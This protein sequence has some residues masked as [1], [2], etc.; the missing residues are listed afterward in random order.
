MTA[1]VSRTEI[2]S[3]EAR[4]ILDNRLEPTLRVTVRT[5]DG[6]TGRADVPR[7]RS[8]GVHEVV[9]LRDGGDRYRGMGVK[10]AARNVEE[11]IEPELLGHSVTDQAGIDRRLRELDGTE[12]GSNLGGNALTGV[13]LA[14]LKAGAAAHDLPL[15]RYLGG[16]AAT[17]IPVPL[18]DLIEGGELGA[19]GLPFQEHQ[20]VPTGADGFEDAIRMCAEVYYELGA[21][22]VESH[23]E[24]ALSVGDEGGYTPPSMTD[25]R[26]AFDSILEAIEECGYGDVFELGIDAAAT[27]FYDP[28]E[29][30]YRLAG[31]AY[32]RG[33][34]LDLYAE[35]VETYPLVSIEDPLEENDFEGFAECT[36]RLDAQIVGDDLFVTNAERLRKGIDVGAGDALLC[37]VN[38]VGTVTDAI[39]A[40]ET[41]RRNG[42]A[43]QVSERS[44][45]TADTWLAEVAV[46]L[47]AGQIK[48]GTTRSERTEQYNRLLEIEAECDG[49]YAAWPR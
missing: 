10:T 35:L 22:L 37:K 33:E 42:Y 40:V 11:R 31:T 17:T 3:I 43:I 36:E 23:G 28:D 18:V 46:G 29:E 21:Q 41:A 5:E 45:Q 7:G 49:G 1:D 25:P 12:D 26:D 6:A 30:T 2:E 34:L 47:R 15:Y 14:T 9:D 13:S 39:E 19:S 32:T 48:T 38:Q 27:H 16:P 20:V 24:R 8:R 4:E 44:G